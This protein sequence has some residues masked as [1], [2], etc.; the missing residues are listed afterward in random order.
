[1][2]RGMLLPAPHRSSAY[3]KLPALL[4]QTRYVRASPRPRNTQRPRPSRTGPVA[5]SSNAPA[6]SRTE[7]VAT[8]NL[9]AAQARVS[10]WL[11]PG[12][13]LFC[14]DG[15][16]ALKWSTPRCELTSSFRQRAL[17]LAVVAC[18]PVFSS[19]KFQPRATGTTDASRMLEPPWTP[20]PVASQPG[21]QRTRRTA[22]VPSAGTEK[23]GG[24]FVFT[25]SRAPG[26]A[27][28]GPSRTQRSTS[29]A[30]CVLPSAA[31]T[32]LNCQSSAALPGV[33]RR[34]VRAPSL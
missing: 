15:R 9:P 1:M 14:F 24:L 4:R 16:V 6:G 17:T 5:P 22:V 28:G 30:W 31:A 23:G 26:T 33:E 18:E 2:R 32:S 12:P 19:L 3:W 20:Y 8:P 11:R 10:E 21:P 27:L 25:S 29:V 13:N 34:S 7:P